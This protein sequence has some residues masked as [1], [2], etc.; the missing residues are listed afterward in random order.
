MDAPPPEIV[1]IQDESD[2]LTVR[3]RVRLLAKAIGMGLV[4]ETKLVTAVSELSR[5]ALVYGGG[6]DAKLEHIE[7]PTGPGIRVTVQDEGPGIP[8]LQLAMQNG[9]TTGKGLG[10]GLPGSKRLVHELDIRSEVGVG[11]TV[12]IVR[13][14]A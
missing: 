1:K 5:N 3:H 14:K 9:Y 6:G 4:D 7:G 2:M 11:T 10:L 13:W 8:D 12:W